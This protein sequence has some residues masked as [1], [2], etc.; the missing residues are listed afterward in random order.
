MCPPKPI[1]IQLVGARYGKKF[2][3]GGYSALTSG[4]LI[5]EISID[6][7][8]F[9]WQV[10][11]VSR[12]EITTAAAENVELEAQRCLSDKKLLGDAQIIETI[13]EFKSEISGTLKI[14]FLI[15]SEVG[16]LSQYICAHSGDWNWATLF[17]NSFYQLCTTVKSYHDTGVAHRDIKPDNII[18]DS[19][20][21]LKLIDKQFVATRNTKQP[22]VCGTY[23]FIPPECLRGGLTEY[24]YAAQ[25]AFAIG[26]TM[27]YILYMLGVVSKPPFYETKVENYKHDM[28]QL[29]YKGRLFAHDD[30][31]ELGKA[32]K[33]RW[34]K[35]HA[36]LLAY[37]P[38]RHELYALE[39]CPD[40]IRVVIINLLSQD[41]KKRLRYFNNI[42]SRRM[43]ADCNAMQ[44][45]YSNPVPLI[46]KSLLQS[47]A[48]FFRDRFFVSIGSNEQGDAASALKAEIKQI[49]TKVHMAKQKKSLAKKSWKSV[50]DKVSNAGYRIEAEY[51]QACSEL[52][53]LR[54]QYTINL[55]KLIELVYNGGVQLQPPETG[56]NHAGD[57]S[58]RQRV[59]DFVERVLV[60]LALSENNIR[61]LFAK[62][63]GNAHYAK[64]DFGSDEVYKFGFTIDDPNTPPRISML[65]SCSTPNGSGACSS[66]AAENAEGAT[67]SLNSSKK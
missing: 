65:W 16:D 67:S 53:H 10:P 24:D 28:E 37:D 56:S 11:I 15:R 49:T 21:I 51:R 13:P 59:I 5:F 34:D 61:E 47:V 50:V 22:T 45:L 20:G 31:S 52:A 58:I 63:V 48:S 6:G 57:L 42:L 19:S 7:D 3:E 23:T 36:F 25:D 32:E 40:E 62:D 44:P 33:K 66:S 35:F 27:L 18:I 1:E 39:G 43:F 29:N 46:T 54:Q 14:D 38:N 55:L 41:W 60:L 12:F 30:S 8:V 2:A 4:K 9:K 26:M 17:R 64:K